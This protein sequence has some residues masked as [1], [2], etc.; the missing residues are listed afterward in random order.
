MHTDQMRARNR[1]EFRENKGEFWKPCPGTTRDYW[2]C[3]YQI[4]TPATGCGMYCS[5]CVLQTYFDHCHQT[6]FTNLDDC[7]SEIA[8]KMARRPGVV[9]FGTGEFAD[10]LYL[11]PRLRLSRH[12]AA[13][14]RPYP[15]ALI[16][17]KTKTAHTRQLADVANPGQVIV[18]FSMNTPR[19]VAETERN[20]APLEARLAAAREAIDNGFWVAFHFDPMIWYAGWEQEYRALTRRILEFI[21]RPNRIAWWSLG[22][23]RCP[24]SLKEHLRERNRHVFLF[25]GE[26]ILGEDRKYRYFRPVRSAFYRAIREEIEA[27]A[28]EI[29]L[30]LCMEN[31]GVWEDSGMIE[32]I[33][34]G[35]TA[36][37][38]RRAEVMLGMTRGET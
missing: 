8:G 10:S 25:S 14:V 18:G 13:M 2:C 12:M 38:D 20:T 7:E 21:D 29:T 32:R 17:F 16:E 30:Y 27:V 24:P 5:Y 3:G 33:P 1:L 34:D 6:V 35:L 19:V 37:L 22:A 31:R 11:E 9:R 4:L 26:I 28:P 15:R 36:Y 23:F